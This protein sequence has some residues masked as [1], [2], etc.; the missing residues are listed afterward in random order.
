LDDLFCLLKG[1]FEMGKRLYVG[2][3]PWTTD[4]SELQRLFE[5][6]GAVRSAEVMMDRVTGRSRGFAFVE[7]E[8][9]GASAAA[10]DALNGKELNGRQLVVNEARERTPRP[11]SGARDRVRSSRESYSERDR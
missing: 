8:E 10:I 6:Y 5:E 11:H 9:D 7:M 1:Q 2:N 3:L 4:A